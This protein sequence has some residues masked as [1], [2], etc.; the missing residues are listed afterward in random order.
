MSSV[1]KGECILLQSSPVFCY[2]ADGSSEGLPAGHGGGQSVK[3]ARSQAEEILQN[4]GADAERIVSQARAQADDIYREAYEKGLHLGE[5]EGLS[6]AILHE[7]QAVGELQELCRRL[8]E[9]RQQVCDATRDE[10]VEFAFDLARKIVNVELD[11]ND[12]AFLALCLDG[13]RHI[14][15]PSEVV[16]KV[17][18][19]EYGMVNR[20]IGEI[21]KA[22]DGLGSL[23]IEP[24]E[25]EPGCCRFET[26]SGIVDSGVNARLKKAKEIL[27]V[28]D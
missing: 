8:E 17:G 20:Y 14:T 10:A 11:R 23:E 21:R 3:A 4:A 1:L 18:P 2:S 22:I 9:G 6:S 28:N 12:K 13:A 7:R 24:V 25:N 19:R 15:A 5:Q 26:G 16:L 27:D